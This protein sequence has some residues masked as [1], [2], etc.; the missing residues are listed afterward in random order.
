MIQLYFQLKEFK[1][2]E[3]LKRRYV[4]NSHP[5]VYAAESFISYKF[6]S[7]TTQVVNLLA[8]LWRAN[9]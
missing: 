5:N 2:A 9:S 1:N 8:E 6:V 3:T 7:A 4:N